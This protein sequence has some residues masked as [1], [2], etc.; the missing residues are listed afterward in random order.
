MNVIKTPLEGVLVLEPKVF[1]DD[2]GM[3]LES[4]SLERYRA[5]GITEPFVQDNW[6]RSKKGTLRGM[7]FQNPRAQG[8]LVSVT[9]GAVFDVA[10]DI[11]KSSPTFGKWFG[12]ELSEK[13][14]RQFWIPPGFAHGFMAL[15]DD[16]DFLYKCTEVY[17]PESDAGI[18][19]NDPDIGIEWPMNITPLLSK[20][21]A[22]APRLRDCTKLFA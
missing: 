9:H 5:I 3:F 18:L 1:K 7:H 6:S 8:K 2:R 16:S 17:V 22:A 13:N 11:R 14:C 15:E 20:K 12:V 19:W 10:V 4:F 21:D